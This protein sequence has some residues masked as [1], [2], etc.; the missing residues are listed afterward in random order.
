VSDAGTGGS[1]EIA[2]GP[3]YLDTVTTDDIEVSI[4]DVIVEAM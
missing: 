1:L 4:D 3:H 2:V